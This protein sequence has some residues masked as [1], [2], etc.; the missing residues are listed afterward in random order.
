MVTSV[1]AQASPECQLGDLLKG[2][3]FIP[4]LT[5]RARQ[6][7]FEGRLGLVPARSIQGRTGGVG[8]VTAS[9][10]FG[11]PPE[12]KVPRP[13]TSVTHQP[14]VT[15]V[16]VIIGASPAATAPYIPGGR[17]RDERSECS[18]H[19]RVAPVARQPGSRSDMV[20]SVSAQASPE[21]QLG[22]FPRG[23]VLI[24][25]LTLRARQDAFE[26]RLGLVPARSIQGR[27]G[28]VGCVTA[29]QSFG[30][31]PE[32]KVPRPGTSVTHQPHVT[33]VLVIIG[34]SPAA[35]APYMLRQAEPALHHS[36]AVTSLAQSHVTLAWTPSAT[37]DVQPA[38]RPPRDP[39]TADP[40]PVRPAA[41]ARSSRA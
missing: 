35:T 5:L 17:G 12:V 2:T 40:R 22:D 14:H 23:T 20:T 7:A 33:R 10:S 28:G 21:C 18:A 1:S 39:V 9:Q 30:N 38:P 15:R 13:G 25:E 11:N 8:C 41:N 37:P 3:V 4:E 24:P 31:P 16:L 26:G 34:A 27:T 6:D 36:G 29:S 32:V 19:H